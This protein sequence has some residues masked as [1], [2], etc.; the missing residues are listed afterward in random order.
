MVLIEDDNDEPLSFCVLDEKPQPGGGWLDRT[1]PFFILQKVSTLLR[2]RVGLV[3]F[4]LA[5]GV[6]QHD[7][8]LV[9]RLQTFRRR[10][11]T[12][13]FADLTNQ[14][15]FLT[16][17]LD[18]ERVPTG[19]QLPSRQDV[20]DYLSVCCPPLH[21]LSI[22]RLA[23]HRRLRSSCKT[24]ASICATARRSHNCRALI[25]HLLGTAHLAKL[26]V[27]TPQLCRM[28]RVARASK[29]RAVLANDA[30]VDADDN[31][32]DSVAAPAPFAHLS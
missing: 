24:M 19:S 22:D 15:K 27:L 8:F 30:S 29:A 4:A 10:Q 16:F 26:A 21:C 28:H 7:R 17:S 1:L 25:L 9:G 23:L 14:T 12:E 2:F 11:R 32:A 13:K 6:F 31:G 20:V 18:A 3:A 5:G